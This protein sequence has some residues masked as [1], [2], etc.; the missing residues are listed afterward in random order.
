MKKSSRSSSHKTRT[1]AIR[2][3]TSGW[4]YKHWSG[5]FYPPEVK[6]RYWLEHYLKHFDTVEINNTFYN[7]PS[8]RTVESWHKR[9]P[10]DFTFAVK[11]SR[12]ITHIKRI[13]D[14]DESLGIFFSRIDSLKGNLGPI[15]FQLPPSLKLDYQRLEDFLSLLPHGYMYAVEFRNS[16]WLEDSIFDLLASKRVAFCIHDLLDVECPFIV[17]AQFAYIRFHG[18]NEKYGGSYPHGVLSRYATKIVEV[19]TQQKSV[20]AYFNNDAHG[21]AVKNAKTLI[22]SISRLISS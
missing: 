6:P 22:N 19:A 10:S 4:S 14:I 18:Y 11:A 17:T 7:L 2:I 15:L 3:G 5:I 1:G 20:Y 9:V 16:S 13:K 12:F 8:Q 21:Y